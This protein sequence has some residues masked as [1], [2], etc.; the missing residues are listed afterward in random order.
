MFGCT[1]N[2][3][4]V[5]SYDFLSHCT[6]VGQLSDSTKALTKALIHGLV[7]DACRWLGPP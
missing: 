7:P 2:P 5:Y 4:T 1:V 3:L 6:T